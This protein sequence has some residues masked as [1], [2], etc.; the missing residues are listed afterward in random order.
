MKYKVFDVVELQ[1]NNLATIL[2]IENN[3]YTVEEINSKGK[4]Q[5][6]KDVT[7]E[8]IKKLKFSK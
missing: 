4:T 1:N 8:N 6:I 3:I 5:G 2:K 7:N